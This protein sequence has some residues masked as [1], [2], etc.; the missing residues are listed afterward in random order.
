MK[1]NFWTLFYET[2]EPI[3]YLLCKAEEKVRKNKMGKI[4]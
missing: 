1:E 3:C 4:N 2:G